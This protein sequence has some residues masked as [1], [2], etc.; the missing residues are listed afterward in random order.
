MY[1]RQIERKENERTN[2][3]ERKRE[4]RYSS[5]AFAV[6]ILLN[7]RVNIRREKKKLIKQSNGRSNIIEL[8]ECVRTHERESEQAL[9]W[10][11]LCLYIVQ[12]DPLPVH[13]I[14]ANPWDFPSMILLKTMIQASHHRIPILHY[15]PRMYHQHLGFLHRQISIQSYNINYNIFDIVVD[16]SMEDLRVNVVIVVLSCVCMISLVR[17]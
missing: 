4:K 2:E 14:L 3:R 15:F 1:V 8:K 7:Q 17:S 12:F 16:Y 11:S 5:I 13:R 9:P 10:S 6:V